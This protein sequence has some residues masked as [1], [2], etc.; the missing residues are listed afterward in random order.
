MRATFPA[1]VNAP[2]QYGQRI[3]A[4]V[5]YLLHYQMLPEDRL[6]EL[7]R[8]VFGVKLVAATIARMIRSYAEQLAD[9]VEALR[10]LVAGAPVKHMD[11]T[12]FRIGDKTQW[13][14]IAS[15]AIL[16]FYRFCARRG[17]L[18]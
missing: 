14:H 9:F 3:T 4:F 2:V 15:T 10:K 18:L 12:G 1:G 16:T 11:E 8:D 7:M 13:L 17:S 6:A 5:L